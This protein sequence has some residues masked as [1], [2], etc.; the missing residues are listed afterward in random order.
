MERGGRGTHFYHQSKQ[1]KQRWMTTMS[2]FVIGLPC[3]PQRRGTWK[4]FSWWRGA[5]LMFLLWWLSAWADRREEQP[6]LMA[7]MRWWW[8][9][10]GVGECGC[11]GWQHGGGGGKRAFGLLMTPNRASAFADAQ[12]LVSFQERDLVHMYSINYQHII[13]LLWYNW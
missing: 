2:S 7:M 11:H 3:H 4:W 10:I 12:N 13:T 9:V 5:F 6:L 8:W 1:R